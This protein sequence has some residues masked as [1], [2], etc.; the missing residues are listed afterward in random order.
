MTRYQKLGSDPQYAPLIADVVAHPSGLVSPVEFAILNPEW[1]TNTIDERLTT[2]TAAGVFD[3]VQG[4]TDE[5]RTYYYV[6]DE[7]RAAFDRNEMFAPEP[8][9]ELF[10]RIDHSD[11][12]R[13]LAERPR[14][15][16]A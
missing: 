1:S 14:P 16:V 12:F 6:T 4:E 3:S 2:L 11:R 13:E 10:N 5:Q 8:L 9:R 7:A 15:S